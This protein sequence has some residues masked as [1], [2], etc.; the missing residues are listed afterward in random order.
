MVSHIISDFYLPLMSRHLHHL[1]NCPF[2]VK[3]GGLKGL[4]LYWEVMHAF[5]LHI[6]LIFFVAKRYF[7]LAGKGLC[8]VVVTR[9]CRDMTFVAFTRFF[10]LVL[11]QTFMQTLRI[12][13]RFLHKK[14]SME[15]LFG[16]PYCILNWLMYIWGPFLNKLSLFLALFRT[17]ELG[18]G[19]FPFAWTQY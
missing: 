4:F 6:L 17:Y 10:G 13:C 1:T 9:F 18:I 12:L 14:C 16:N 3:K 5:K 7:F 19:N 8:Y 11:M 15:A 2:E